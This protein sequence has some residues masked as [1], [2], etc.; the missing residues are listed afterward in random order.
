MAALAGLGCAGTS[1]T[2]NAD[3][4]AL[5]QTSVMTQEDVRAV[6]ELLESRETGN[7][8]ATAEILLTLEDLE[9][10]FDRLEAQL[11]DLLDGLARYQRPGSGPGVAP[12]PGGTASDPGGSQIPPPPVSGTPAD[13]RS[14]Y[15]AAYLEVTRGHYDAAVVA[16]EAFVRAHPSSDLADNAIYWIGESHYASRDFNRAAEAFVR[17]IDSYPSGDK[18]P[19][20]MLKLGFAFQENGD[21]A[22]ARRYLETL[23]ERF[24]KSEEAAKARARLA[25]L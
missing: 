24:P 1:L 21:T 23:T 25:E 18:V 7:S 13:P 19:A 10:R 3:I 14:E 12:A 9:A 8:D 5:R 2:E 11:T 17:L 22:A 4:D 6:R 20:A 16:F 15:E